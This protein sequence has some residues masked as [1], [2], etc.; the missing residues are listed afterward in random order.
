VVGQ[1][2]EREVGVPVVAELLEQ[3]TPPGGLLEAGAD[4]RPRAAR[5]ELAEQ[6]RRGA[7]HAVGVE[8]GDHVRADAAVAEL[9]GLG[10]GRRRQDAAPGGAAHEGAE[11]QVRRAA[12]GRQ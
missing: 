5:A 8:A 2:P 6:R 12:H 10:A 11:G 9:G 7:E 1:V 4:R 3:A